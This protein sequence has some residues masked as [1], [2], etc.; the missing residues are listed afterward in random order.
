MSVQEKSFTWARE[1]GLARVR[2]SDYWELTKPRLSFLSVITAL[3]G[4]WAAGAQGTLTGFIALFFGTAFAAGSAGALNQWL[5]R[6]TDA[7]MARTRKR[8]IPAGQ[9]PPDLA[10][11]YGTV[12][13][14]GGTALLFWGT[15]PLAAALA[16]FTILSYLLIYTPLKQRTIWNTLIGAVPGAV[17]PLIGWAAA[18]GSLD[19]M[20]WLLFAILFTWQIPHFMAIAWIH[21]KDYAQAGHR[22]LPSVD[23]TGIRTARHSLIFAGLMVAAS[24]APGLLGQTSYFYTAA[25]LCLGGWMVVRAVEFCR[26]EQRELAAR[27]LF[28][29]S[30]I[31][32]PVL[33]TFLV[34]DLLWLVPAA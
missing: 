34:F 25:A 4:Y 24:V 31:Y 7:L 30:I 12:L 33:L 13:G 1:D 11:A 29:A 3:V 14:L 8:P 26:E 19:P 32:L 22:M 5:E 15:H 23:P 28:V 20:S 16:L 10:V 27:R 21:R 18:T 6:R 17:P 2:L 9:V